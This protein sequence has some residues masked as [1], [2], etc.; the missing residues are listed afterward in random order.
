[1]LSQAI[2][3]FQQDLEGMGK[4]DKVAGMTFSEFGRRIKSNASLGTDHGSA[5]PVM[6]FGS[7]LNTSPTQVAATQYPVP[8]MIGASPNLPLNANG[9]RP[10]ANAI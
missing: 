3:A 1:M 10:S 2:G 8:G 5:A 9:E 4:A 6:F 7:A